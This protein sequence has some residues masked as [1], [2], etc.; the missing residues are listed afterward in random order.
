M[1]GDPK[2]IATDDEMPADQYPRHRRASTRSTPRAHGV[3]A[4]SSR[5]QDTLALLAGHHV[6]P[7]R[8]DLLG[9]EEAAERRHSVL[10][11]H[12]HV[13]EPGLLARRELAQVEGALGIDHARP[14]ARRAVP[15]EDRGTLADLLRLVRTLGGDARAVKRER[16]AQAQNRC[17]Q[18]IRAKVHTDPPWGTFP[19]FWR[20]TISPRPP[21][22]ESTVMYCL[23]LRVHVIGCELTPEPVLNCQSV[24]PVSASTAMNSPVILPV[25]RSPPPVAR[26]ADQCGKSAS[27]I[28]QRGCAVIGSIAWK[29]PHG[30]SAG[31]F[32]G[33]LASMNM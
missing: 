15:R 5:Y 8:V 18:S 33:S 10:A 9:A 4:S 14:V 26:T 19:S 21:R 32:S 22:P 20:F 13:H 12:E 23:P 24:W 31:R 7:E 11:S 27:G 17:S 29:C 3:A 6:G 16:A 1:R 2:R 28:C 25:N 30:R